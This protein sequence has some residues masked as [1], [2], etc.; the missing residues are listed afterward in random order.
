MQL[1]ETLDLVE[2]DRLSALSAGAPAD[3]WAVYGFELLRKT[4]K[5]GRFR[6]RVLHLACYN[7]RIRYLEWQE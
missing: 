7:L 1:L 3:S 4:G 2:L 5:A 6:L